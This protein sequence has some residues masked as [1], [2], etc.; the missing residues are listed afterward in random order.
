MKSKWKEGKSIRTKAVVVL[1]LR[2]IVTG[3][4]RGSYDYYSVLRFI[5]LGCYRIYLF[6]IF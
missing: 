4:K 1:A 5:T 6:H 2:G 3:E